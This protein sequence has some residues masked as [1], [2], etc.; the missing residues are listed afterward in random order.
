MQAL[1]LRLMNPIIF[2]NMSVPKRVLL[3]LDG[4]P[5]SSFFVALALVLGGCSSQQE[6]AEET[7]PV[8]KLQ[9]QL[10]EVLQPADI[11]I[12]TDS[13]VPAL[14]YSNII[15]LNTLPLDEKKMRFISALLPAILVVKHELE[16]E[17][18]N[19]LSMLKKPAWDGA[20]SLYY[21]ELT[22]LYR[23]DDP[24]KILS[25]METHPNSIVLAQ[26]AV[27]SGWGNSRIFG[28]ANNL[29]GI[30]S[31]NVN[32]PRVAASLKR[33]GKTIY[34]RKYADISE[35]ISDYFVTL[36]RSRPY[37]SFRKAREETDSVELLLPHL[38]Y[39]SERRESYT[40]Q[41]RSLIRFNDLKRF[42]DYRLD[43]AYFVGQKIA[44]K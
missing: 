4:Y 38:L 25:A 35:S 2:V 12:L 40:D 30:W 13:L 39:Y 11:Q 43:S 23:T 10:I 9:P 31:F 33:D 37:A 8:L 6:V 24:V 16:L 42:D 1:L 21:Q 26:A 28:T 29:F 18:A 14:L 44:M 5:W 36:G 20:D 7:A 17:R 3:R 34:L 22:D 41:L 27:E 15:G 19:F 32:E